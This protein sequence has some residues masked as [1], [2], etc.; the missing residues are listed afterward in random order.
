MI[1]IGV[2][3]GGTFTDVVALDEDGTRRFVVKLPTTV[4]DQSV[5]VIEGIDRVIAEN[6]ISVDEVAF[7][8]HGTTAGTNAFLTRRGART[9]LLTTAGF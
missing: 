4:E 8:G 2:D 6:G 1:R 5:S 3:V 7:V 9:A